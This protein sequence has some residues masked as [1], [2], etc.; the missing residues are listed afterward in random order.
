MEFKSI[1]IK[2]RF[3]Q[4][5]T[6]TKDNYCQEMYEKHTLGINKRYYVSMRKSSNSIIGEIRGGSYNASKKLTQ[7]MAERK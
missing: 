2:R 3:R 1:I 5:Q 7:E 6:H 4:S